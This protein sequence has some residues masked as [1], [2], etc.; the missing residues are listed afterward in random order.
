M[1]SRSRLKTEVRNFLEAMKVFPPID[2]ELKTWE[3]ARA[4]IRPQIFPRDYL[5]QKEFAKKMVFKPLSFSGDLMEGYVV[6]SERAF[7]YVL[8]SDLKQWKVSLEKIKETAYENLVEATAKTRLTALRAGRA[9]KQGK[10][11]II[12]VNDGYAAARLLLPAV[13]NEIE[14][15]LGKPCY[16]AIPNRDYLIAWSYDTD[17]EKNSQF[18]NKVIRNF[19]F[20]DHPLS[21]EIYAIV[22]SKIEKKAAIQKP[23]QEEEDKATEE[24]SESRERERDSR[25]R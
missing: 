1:R 19:H 25:R 23:E 10:Y 14:A 20:K 17:R 9:S 3:D 8:K 16:V 24:E 15:K 13:R 5:S 18:E 12:S 22:N 11:L 21:K 7:R 4:R 2:E 6:D